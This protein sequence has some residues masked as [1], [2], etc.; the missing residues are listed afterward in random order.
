MR[1]EKWF[2]GRLIFAPDTQVGNFKGIYHGGLPIDVEGYGLMIPNVDEETARMILNG[3]E[4]ALTSLL[5][6]LGDGQY[7]SKTDRVLHLV[8][9]V[10]NSIY[11]Y[12]PVKETVVEQNPGVGFVIDAAVQSAGETTKRRAIL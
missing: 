2:D 3:N 11:S 10:G 7:K 8:H 6:D 9:K 5:M 1:P 12:T 4:Q